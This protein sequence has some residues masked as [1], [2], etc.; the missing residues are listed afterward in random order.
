V[1][2][3]P[4]L[5]TPSALLLCVA[6]SPF[7]GSETAMADKQTEGAGP[8]GASAPAQSVVPTAATATA[9]DRLRSGDSEAVVELAGRLT[10]PTFLDDLD[11]ERDRLALPPERLQLHLLLRALA[12]SPAPEAPRRFAALAAQV[13]YSYPGAH[14][15]AFIEASRYARDPEAGLLTYW[16]RQL[17]ADGSELER[18]VSVLL[19]NGSTPALAVLE[20][21]L[22]QEPYRE[23][24]VIAW[25]RDGVLRHRQ[26]AGVV[27]LCRALLGHP[28]WSRALKRSALEVLFDYAPERW[29]AIDV[30]PPAPPPRSEL[31]AAVHAALLALLE[32]ARR[33]G[34]AS[35]QDAVRWR[36]ALEP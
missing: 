21:A 22:L 3:T 36:R 32:D 34:V 27:A 14:A 2:E 24:Y 19:D 6:C 10:D 35:R 18:T 17:E 5:L 15:A 8:T 28:E 16:R 25:F 12:A 13:P 9:V 33:A 7:G 1:P 30:A 11:S 20:D 31:T 23:D 29:Y 26:D 4:R